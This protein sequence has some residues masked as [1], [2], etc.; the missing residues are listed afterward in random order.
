MSTMLVQVFELNQHGYIFQR[1]KHRNVPLYIAEV[2]HVFSIL[3]V[4]TVIYVNK[5]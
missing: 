4:K 1:H 5:A 3:F 2:G